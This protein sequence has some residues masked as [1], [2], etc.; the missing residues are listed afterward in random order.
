MRNLYYETTLHKQIRDKRDDRKDRIRKDIDTYGKEVLESDEM[1]EAYEQTHHLWSTVGE[2]TLRVT[3]TSVMVSYALRKL[4]IKVNVPAVV[5]GSLC[6]DLGMLGRSDKY[7]SDQQAHKEHPTESVKV[8]KGI[9]D[10][11][12]EK[13]EDIIERHMWPASGSKAPNSVEGLIVSAADKY[14]A[15]KDIVKGSDFRNTGVR[16]VAHEQK[17]KIKETIETKYKEAKGDKKE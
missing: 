1:K 14:S 10:E 13:S 16:N 2:H 8:A 15:V 3:L 7:K 5:I 11:L 9:V 12:P 4:H 6:H 17:E